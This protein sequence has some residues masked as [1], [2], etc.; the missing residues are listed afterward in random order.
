MKTEIKDVAITLP[1]GVPVKMGMPVYTVEKKGLSRYSSDRKQGYVK[2]WSGDSQARLVKHEVIA[3]N[4][5]ANSRSF[6]LRSDRG[7]E[8]SYSVKDQCIGH[9]YGKK[10]SATAQCKTIDKEDSEGFDSKIESL[11]QR[12]EEDRKRISSL[13]IKRQKLLRTKHS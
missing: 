9:L 4:Q 1:D 6:T 5:N 8:H 12:M 10:S 7:C 11:N 3:V 13:K 2:T